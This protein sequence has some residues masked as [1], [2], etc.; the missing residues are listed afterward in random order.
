MKKR[1]IFLMITA[2][3]VSG[4]FLF[5]NSQHNVQA[6]TQISYT[7]DI[8]P[9]FQSR[10][11][12]CHIGKAKSAGLNLGSYKSLMAGSEDGPVIVPRDAGQSYLVE[13]ITA[14]EMP[15][16]GPKLTPAQIQLI[17]DWVNAGSQN[18]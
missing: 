6:E 16:R 17:T 18:N 8:Q 5:Q 7:K 1:Y 14:G 10:C 11:A 2:F 9:I 13:K 3:L 15:K 12:S 4:Y